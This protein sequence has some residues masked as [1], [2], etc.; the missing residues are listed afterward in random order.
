MRPTD[1]KKV[2]LAYWTYDH[3]EW[4]NYLY[5]TKMKK[6]LLYYYLFRVFRKRQVKVPEVAITQQKIWIGDDVYSFRDNEK[7]LRKIHIREAGKVN[8]IEIGFEKKLGSQLAPGKICIPIPK[9]KLR[10]AIRV[11]ESLGKSIGNRQ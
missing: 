1:H 9:G 11:H 8:I 10:E 3:D 2:F 6:G 4:L 5:W 7:Q